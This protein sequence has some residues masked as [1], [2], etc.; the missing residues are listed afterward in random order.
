M[1]SSAN[2]YTD[3]HMHPVSVH[4]HPIAMQ[5]C[6]EAFRSHMEGLKLTYV[7]YCGHAVT[8]SKKLRSANDGGTLMRLS[9]FTL[10]LQDAHVLEKEAFSPTKAKSKPP[11][12]QSKSIMR[13]ASKSELQKVHDVAV[14]DVR[15]AFTR[16]L[17][18]HQDELEGD[19]H[20]ALTFVEFLEAVARIAD[21]R[22]MILPM[23]PDLSLT[24]SHVFVVDLTRVLAPLVHGGL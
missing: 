8:A 3:T 19:D 10:L 7:L 11:R 9:D 14:R 4:T 20:T 5:E 13:H 12:H 17:M 18:T 22:P 6:D 23:V 15:L 16:S 1:K 21:I 2:K 24:H